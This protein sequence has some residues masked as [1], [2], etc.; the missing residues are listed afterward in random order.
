MS[1]AN[2]TTAGKPKVGGAIH[3]APLGTAL[4]TDAKTALND[5]FKSLGYCD[6]SGLV[7]AKTIESSIIH[8]WGGDAVLASQNKKEDKFTFTL[9]EALNQDVLATVHGDANVTG[10]L[11]AGIAVSVKAAD[12][13]ASAWVIDMILRNGALKRIVVPEGTITELGEVVYSDGA[14]VGYKITIAAMPDT[15]GNTHYEY[16]M[17]AS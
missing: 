4:P 7:N 3:R 8:A 11:E 15:T 13:A 12:L 17:A 2:Y 16:I 9:I 10:S 14:V 5:A 6:E 1:N